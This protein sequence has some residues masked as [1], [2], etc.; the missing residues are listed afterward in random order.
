[1]PWLVFGLADL[2]TAL[3]AFGPAAV[4]MLAP[5]ALR[6]ASQYRISPLMLVHG[7]QAGAFS[8]SS[9]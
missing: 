2:L 3:G 9:V 5:V 4:A 6:F 7:T 8:P 1:M